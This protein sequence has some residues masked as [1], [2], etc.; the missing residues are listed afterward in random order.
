MG[1]KVLVVLCGAA[2]WLTFRI[3]SLLS[4]VHNHS[5][6]YLLELQLVATQLIALLIN[7]LPLSLICICCSYLYCSHNQLVLDTYLDVLWL[8]F[9]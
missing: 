8:I 9:L 7:E 2:L 4:T 1:G 5:S 6:K 3:L